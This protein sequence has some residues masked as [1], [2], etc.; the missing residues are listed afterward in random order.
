MGFT[1]R[2]WAMMAALGPLDCHH[3]PWAGRKT[4]EPSGGGGVMYQC[5]KFTSKPAI[6]WNHP[7]YG[8]LF[9]LSSI[10]CMGARTK[11]FRTCKVRLGSIVAKSVT[12][13]PICVA[14]VKT[15]CTWFKYEH[16]ATLPPITA[17]LPG[18]VGA[19]VQFVAAAEVDKA[20]ERNNERKKEKLYYDD[21]WRRKRTL[22]T[23]I[24]GGPTFH[25]NFTLFRAYNHC[26]S[27]LKRIGY[28]MTNCLPGS[29]KKTVH[30]DILAELESPLYSVTSQHCFVK[31]KCLAV[32]LSRSIGASHF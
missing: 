21:A 19:W 9:T 22:Q 16:L 27:V 26:Y 10:T 24:K 8:W 1:A 14:Y 2:P 23:N 7:K 30:S 5:W 29:H 31:L 20:K 32:G 13:P 15:N 4:H 18:W 6:L 12:G 28:T 17:C 11:H 25:P 3:G